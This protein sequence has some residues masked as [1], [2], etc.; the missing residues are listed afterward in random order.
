[1]VY[2]MIHVSFGFCRGIAEVP[3]NVSDAGSAADP[4]LTAAQVPPPADGEGKFTV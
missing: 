2:F 3:E 4:A 1:M